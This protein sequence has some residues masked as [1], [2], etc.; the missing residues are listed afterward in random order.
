MLISAL[1]HFHLRLHLLGVDG[2]L[3]TGRRAQILARSLLCSARVLSLH[4][5]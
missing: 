2:V 4:F 1:L 3:T 5:G